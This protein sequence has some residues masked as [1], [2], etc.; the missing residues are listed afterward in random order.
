MNHPAD[1]YRA[2]LDFEITFTNGG[3]LRGREFR[4][5][6]DHPGMTEDELAAAL[7]RDL[8]LLMVGRV[9]IHSRQV[10]RGPH[11]RG[12]PRLQVPG[13]PGQPEPPDPAGPPGGRAAGTAGSAARG[14]GRCGPARG[15]GGRDRRGRSPRRRSPRRRD[16]RGR[17]WR[18][19]AAPG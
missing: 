3:S 6:I 5:D 14:R 9:D 11:R 1:E 13:L 10:M 19:R 18:E 16:S 12:Q 2:E 4:I 17:G 7:I 15:P 8:G